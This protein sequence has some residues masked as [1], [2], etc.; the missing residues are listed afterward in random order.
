LLHSADGKV[1]SEDLFRK[2]K[3]GL[4]KHSRR[5][6]YVCFLRQSKVEIVGHVPTIAVAADAMEEQI[7]TARAAGMVFIV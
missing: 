6:K 4:L 2:P 5:G 3:Y 1:E 7:A